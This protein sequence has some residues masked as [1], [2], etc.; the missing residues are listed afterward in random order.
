M[1][2]ADLAHAIGNVP[3]RLHHDGVDFAVWC[4]YKYLNAGPGAIGG[5]FVHER[6]ARRD[7]L[8]RL[9]GWWGH[10]PETRFAMDRAR[11][12]V[13]QPGAAGWQLSN[14]PVLAAA[15]LLASLALFDEAG[16]E[17]RLA[18]ARAQFALLVDVLDAAPGDRLE[19]ITPRGD[20][21]HGCQVSVR[22]PGRAERI[23]RALRRDGF[24]VDVRPPDVIRVAPV[25]LFN[26]HEEVARLGLRLVELAGGA[27]GTC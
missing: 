11:R 9:A 2:G 22:L 14:P 3:L 25:P 10:D 20:G 18:K 5:A 27:D 16:E 12:F 19:V 26:T 7:D 8:P 13:P 4:S 21:A 23:A 6:H 24:V 17:R 1:F 15:P